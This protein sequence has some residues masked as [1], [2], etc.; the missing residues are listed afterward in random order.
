VT[1]PWGEKCREA[2]KNRRTAGLVLIPPA[3]LVLA[4]LL[5]AGGG[6]CTDSS[7][8]PGPRGRQGAGQANGQQ[9]ALFDYAIDSVNR[10]DEFDS[11]EMLP[12]ILARIN[13]QAR[14]EK[15][16]LDPLLTTWPEPE[17]LRQ[18][19]DRLDQ[20]MRLQSPPADWKPDPLLEGLPAELRELPAIG[21]LGKLRFSGAD[22][23]ALRGAA[24][25]CNVSNW[26][27]GD[28]LDDVACAK[29]LFDWTIRNVQ[30]DADMVPGQIPLVPW[31][32]LFFG[33]G[34][35]IERARVF[36][37]LA[38][39]QGI[40][41]VMLALGNAAEPESLR[42]W[43]VAVISEGELHLFD[44]ALGLPIPGPDGVKLDATGQLDIRPA[45]LA[46]VADDEE[47]LRQLD[48][49]GDVRYGVEASDLQS[50]VALL[51]ASPDSL[52]AR[53]MLVESHLD[54]RQ[55]MVLT[56]RP[57]RQ[58]KLLKDS[59]RVTDARLWSFPFEVIQQ[60][61][62]LDPQGVQ[63]RLVA[64]LPF[65]MVSLEGN[66][67]EQLRQ[68]IAFEQEDVFDRKDQEAGYRP[69]RAVSQR[70]LVGRPLRKGRMLYLKGEFGGSSGAA[71]CLQ[72]ARP[73]NSKLDQAEEQLFT[74]LFTIYRQS[75]PN[76]TEDQIRQLSADEARMRRKLFDQAKEHANY[77]LGLI[78]FQQESY[79]SAVDYFLTRTLLASPGGPWVHAARYNLARTYEVS[80]QQR[81]AIE[82][83]R[84]DTTSPGYHGNLLRARWLSKLA[85]GEEERKPAQHISKPA[86]EIPE[87]QV[88]A[89]QP[90]AN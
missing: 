60:R 41:A 4:W 53:M 11:G 15:T 25:L 58:A 38:R 76:R 82:Y 29:R 31:E 52:S 87:P 33:H 27:R 14:Q 79:A 70:E 71:Q 73:A 28:E 23:F 56:T 72:Q 47:L 85:L 61:L 12:R 86:E 2:F 9:E 21:E 1:K 89:P 6:G 68:M 39:Q 74:N 55:E 67:E 46:E 22:G 16:S 65:Y 57:T 78:A 20:W 83:Y 35:A 18:I 66:A 62:Q 32:T 24:W 88:E 50:L 37:L 34:T 44:P 40:D 51:E 64:L 30:L 26:A 45:T 90:A 63:Q 17:M 13:Q 75:M 3:V 81:K 8:A 54:R 7:T 84:S 19:V 80:G 49:E 10:L 42:P 48:V 59:D 69:L 43:A 5:F 36:I 77:W